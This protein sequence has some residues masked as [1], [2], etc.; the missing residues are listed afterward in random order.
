MN[1]FD[2]RTGSFLVRIWEERRD[3]P[4][5]PRVWRGSIVNVQTGD[6]TYFSTLL[7]VCRYLEQETGMAGSAEPDLR[8]PVRALPGS[9]PAGREGA[10]DGRAGD[11][12]VAGGDGS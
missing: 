2:E 6:L 12:P 1:S 11:R 8:P 4:D 7:E 9:S 5:A 3:L 10:T